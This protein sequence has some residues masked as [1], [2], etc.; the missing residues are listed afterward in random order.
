MENT[1]LEISVLNCAG[2]HCE[3]RDTR[4]GRRYTCSRLFS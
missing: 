1:D 4:T 3:V 2:G